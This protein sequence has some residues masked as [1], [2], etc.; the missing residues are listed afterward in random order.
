LGLFIASEQAFWT[1]HNSQSEPRA[2]D[3]LQRRGADRHRGSVGG[4]AGVQ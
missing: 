4:M 2:P 3:L 1:N